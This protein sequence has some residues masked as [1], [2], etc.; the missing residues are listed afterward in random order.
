MADILEDIAERA[1][2][3]YGA[4]HCVGY[5]PDDKPYI[6]IDTTCPFYFDCDI[7]STGHGRI[8]S[9]HEATEWRL[10]FWDS[11]S[12]GGSFAR[13]LSAADRAWYRRRWW[14]SL[15]KGSLVFRC[16]RYPRARCSAW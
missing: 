8:R 5:G 15:V 4:G 13:S 3:R 14:H 10:R 9:R 6:C 11:Y 2:R 1:L 7:T 12:F 16:V